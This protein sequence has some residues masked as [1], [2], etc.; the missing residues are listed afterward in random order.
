MTSKPT[1]CRDRGRV[2]E[3]E[4]QRDTER[5]GKKR[6]RVGRERQREGKDMGGKTE[7]VR[8]ER[9]WGGGDTER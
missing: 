4:G 3:G 2:W 6:Q 9:E 5:V 8:K 1:V 7:R